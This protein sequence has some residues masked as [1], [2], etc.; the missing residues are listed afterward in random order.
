[1][2]WRETRGEGRQVYQVSFHPADMRIG[3][4]S[5]LKALL[6]AHTTHNMHATHTHNMHT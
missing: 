1:M 5:I 6:H 3:G 4:H 2:F